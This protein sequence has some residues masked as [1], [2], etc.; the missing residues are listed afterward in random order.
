MRAWQHIHKLDSVLTKGW[1]AVTLQLA[2]VNA[3]PA[4]IMAFWRLAA[5]VDA[6][7]LPPVLAAGRASAAI[8][9]HAGTR[10]ALGCLEATPAAI[11]CTLSNPGS[12]GAW[13]QALERLSA[14]APLLVVGFLRQVEH[15]LANGDGAHVAD[16]VAAGL[17]ATARDKVR[18][19]AVFSLDDPLASALLA[20]AHGNAGFAECESMLTLFAA[21]LWGGNPQLHAALPGTDVAA[22]RPVIALGTVLFP[23]VFRGVPA[24]RLRA[25]YRAATA[26]AMAHLTLPDCRL[27]LLSLRPLQMA[28]VELF[29]DARVE[30]LAI[31]RFPGLLKVWGEWHIARPAGPVTAT[32]LMARLAHALLDPNYADP[33]G[34]VQKGRVMFAEA[35][36]SRHDPAI[37]RAIGGLLGNDLGQMRLQFD[38]RASGLLPA[39]RDDNAHLWELPDAPDDAISIGVDTARGS[40]GGA[41]DTQHGDGAPAPPARTSGLDNRGAVLAT[42]P[43]WDTASRRERPDWTTLRDSEPLLRVGDPRHEKDAALRASIARL[44]RGSVVGQRVR[45]MLQEDGETL[46]IDAVIDAA[47]ARRGHRQHDGRVY[48]DRRP[49]GRDLAT[50]VILDVSQSTAA[51]ATDGRTVLEA[52]RAAVIGLAEALDA[53]NDCYALRAFA[54]AGRD[55]VRLTRLKDFDEPFSAVVRARIEGLSAALSTRLGAALRHAAVELRPLHLSRKM[56]LVLTDG[57]P[58]DIDVADPDELVEDA[59][60]AVAALRLAGVDVFGI[61]ID[62]RELGSGSEIF[63]R[64]NTMTVRRL[65]ELPARLA[66]VYFRLSRR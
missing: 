27:P 48:R 59:R 55:D 9:R 22:Q 56:V 61:V 44:V 6:A 30:A 3:G 4:C 57:E 39:Y 51:I 46:D 5:S 2:H 15:L 36:S 49:H 42:Y 1:A 8:C 17:K 33:D 12:L 64:H 40:D 45:Q 58:S 37:S 35:A 29:E 28:M 66:D 13:W 43:E 23:P 52:E 62:P 41:A 26:H 38:A 60:R 63:G 10:A 21:G 32:S 31:E 24:G 18:R 25:L 7:G 20:R 65:S 11:R 16:F 54:S 19:H 47:S 34:F 50:L 14:E 53:R